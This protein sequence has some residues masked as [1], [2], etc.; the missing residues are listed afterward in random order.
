MKFRTFAVFVGPSVLLMF[1]FIT[2]PLISVFWQSFHL[3]KVVFETV[4]VETCTPSFTGQTCVT[5]EKTRPQLDEDG[6]I[7]SEIRFVGFQSYSSLIEPKKAF[8]AIK[9]LDWSMFQTIN[10]WKALRFTLTFTFI[11]LPLVVGVGFAIALAVNNT[12]RAMKGYVIFISL[13][14]FIITPVIGALSIRWLFIGD[15]ILTAFLEWWLE[16]DIALFAQGWT[17]EVLMLFYRVWHSAPF[18]F[19][20]LYAGLQTVNQDSLESAI[21]DGANRWQRLR[22]IIV[23]HLMPLIIFISLIHLMDAY[24]VFEEVVGFSSEAHVISLQWLT[25]DLLTPDDS[26]S[27]SIGRASASAMLTMVGISI[28]LVPLLRRTWRDHREG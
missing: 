10:F 26:G 1:L 7:K 15:G 27:R 18:A 5:E 16:R 2:A 19:V 3:T 11:T 21:I 8:Q 23:P 13:L 22:F 17:I 6:R 12:L 20:V 28:I 4:E 14:P 24:R 9:K 25:Y